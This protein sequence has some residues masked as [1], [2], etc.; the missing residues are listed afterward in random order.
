MKQKQSNELET[1]RWIS[2]TKKK[3]DEVMISITLEE[4]TEVQRQKGRKTM[5]M[6]VVGC[7]NDGGG[8]TPCGG[9]AQ[10]AN[11]R[12]QEETTGRN[13][14]TWCSLLWSGSRFCEVME[15]GRERE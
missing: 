14:V 2:I 9:G 12:S 15:R 11:Y 3:I 13:K 6:V 4:T 8:A 1:Q 5:V 7:R 10:V